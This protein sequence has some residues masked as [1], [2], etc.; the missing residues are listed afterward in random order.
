MRSMVLACYGRGSKPTDWRFIGS[1]AHSHEPFV[2]RSLRRVGKH[3]PAAAR[4]LYAI[5]LD[6][7]T[8]LSPALA[9]AFELRQ[10]LDKA[11]DVLDL[12]GSQLDQLTP[13]NAWTV[14]RCYVEIF[15]EITV[16]PYW[17]NQSRGAREIEATKRT[18]LPFDATVRGRKPPSSTFSS[19]STVDRPYNCG[20]YN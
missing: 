1:S 7:I 14:S 13:A 12:G 11:A 15:E 6:K 18:R 2:E 3:F 5:L 4:N 10:Y 8:E 20:R 9:S 19:T 16:A 17:K